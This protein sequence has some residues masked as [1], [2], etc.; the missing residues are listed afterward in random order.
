MRSEPIAAV[1]SEISSPPSSV[2]PAIIGCSDEHN[3]PYW[4]GLIRGVHG[5]RAGAMS[6]KNIRIALNLASYRNWQKW[7]PPYTY[8]SRARPHVPCHVPCHV[9][10]V[11]APPDRREP[12]EVAARSI[13]ARALTVVADHDE[14]GT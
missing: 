14:L 6:L 11:D 1:T 2:A 3:Q 13:K 10:L 4:A 7:P 12:L 8:G 9:L 5:L